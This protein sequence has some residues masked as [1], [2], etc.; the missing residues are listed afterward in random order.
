VGDCLLICLLIPLGRLVLVG[1]GLVLA[2]LRHQG[3]LHHHPGIHPV[4]LPLEVLPI[5]MEFE[6]VHFLY[7]SYLVG[8]VGLVLLPDIRQ[9][10]LH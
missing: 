2:V 3:I 9:R 4:V 10:R 6:E 8:L 5:R 7:Q 1:E